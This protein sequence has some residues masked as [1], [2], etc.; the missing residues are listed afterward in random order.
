MIET[1]NQDKFKRN[2]FIVWKL[3]YYE[4]YVDISENFIY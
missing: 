4:S 3:K 2:E 1:E